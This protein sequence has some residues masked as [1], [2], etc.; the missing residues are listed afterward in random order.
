M[1]TDL[2]AEFTGRAEETQ[3]PS[4]EV[5]FFMPLY[6]KPDD[7]LVDCEAPEGSRLFMTAAHVTPF[8]LQGVRVFRVKPTGPELVRGAIVC[9]NC[10]PM[11]FGTYE[12]GRVFLIAIPEGE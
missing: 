5:H 12:R 8:Y 2:L 7:M 11:W 10:L 3:V 6:V 1:N 4:N 9:G